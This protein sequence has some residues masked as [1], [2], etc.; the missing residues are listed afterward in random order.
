[1]VES[2]IVGVGLLG[3]KNFQMSPILAA[4]SF[5]HTP[6]QKVKNQTIAIC[7]IPIFAAEPMIWWTFLATFI[8]AFCTHG[9]GRRGSWWHRFRFLRWICSR[10]QKSLI[11]LTG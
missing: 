3:A 8:L 1:M 4:S 10:V 2:T 9:R 11:L 6:C 7:H 5:D